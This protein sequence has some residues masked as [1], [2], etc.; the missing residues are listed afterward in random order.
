MGIDAML[1]EIKA[2]WTLLFIISVQIL[3][4]AA[5]SNSDAMRAEAADDSESKNDDGVGYSAVPMDFNVMC[6]ANDCDFEVL[7]GEMETNAASWHPADEGI[8]LTGD[9]AVL[10][11]DDEFAGH[12]DQ[13]LACYRI[14]LLGA[15]DKTVQMHFEVNGDYGVYGMTSDEDPSDEALQN[16]PEG[17]FKFK[18]VVNSA[19]WKTWSMEVQTLKNRGQMTFA[20]RKTGKGDARFYYIELSG[21]TYCTDNAEELD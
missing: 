1:S 14:K 5:E 4:C 17:H 7:E 21:E 16:L 8:R 9:I 10:S 20:I 18:H 3:S 11:T 2:K 12:P 13:N 6:T 19:P 15:W